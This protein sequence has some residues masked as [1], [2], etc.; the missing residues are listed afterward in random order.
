MDGETDELFTHHLTEQTE[1]QIFSLISSYT[2][3]HERDGVPVRSYILRTLGTADL[4]RP[5]GYNRWLLERRPK[6]QTA[7][8]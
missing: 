7:W 1:A 6:R 2:C 5:G 3:S 4:Q 8:Q